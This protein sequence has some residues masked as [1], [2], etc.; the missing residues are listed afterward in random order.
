[1]PR[2][3]PTSSAVDVVQKGRRVHG[4]QCPTCEV[5]EAIFGHNLF[6]IV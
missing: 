2:P 6:D 3:D 5:T 4:R 1:V